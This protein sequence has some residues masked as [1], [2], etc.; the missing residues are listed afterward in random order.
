MKYILNNIAIEVTRKC[1]AKCSHCM[2]GESQNIDT[3][4]EIIDSILNN[5]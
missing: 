3:T 4:K 2:R 5:E 1:N